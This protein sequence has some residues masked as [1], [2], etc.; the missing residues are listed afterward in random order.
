MKPILI[1]AVLLLA[2][3]AASAQAAAATLPNAFDRP[4]AGVA[5][6]APAATPALAPAAA[7]TP[8]NAKAEDT[9][10]TLIAGS[11][12]GAM[13]YA[14]MT[15][16]L[17][18][19]MREQEGQITPLLTSLGAVQAVDFLDSQN[20]VDLFAVTFATA[21]TQWMIGFEPGGKVTALRFRPAPTEPA[22]PPAT[23]AAQ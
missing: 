20:G 8:A 12:S 14:L 3:S 23:P 19:M 9:L 6:A 15:E 17:A 4:T 18:A 1:A 7:V 22:T 13:D 5:S 16:D 21:A 10:R 11:Q 2:P